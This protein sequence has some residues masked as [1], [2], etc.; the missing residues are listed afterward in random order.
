MT[1]NPYP[2]GIPL[3]EAGRQQRLHAKALE[4]RAIATGNWGQWRHYDVPFGIPGGSGW[5]REI[6]RVA[7]ND[8][9]AVLIRPVQTAWGL[10]HH[11][12][13]RT[14]SN[15]EP[16]WRDKQRIKDELFARDASAIEVMPPSGEV[17]DQADMYHI[18]VLP[19]GFDLPFSLFDARHE[20]NANGVSAQ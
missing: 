17:I 2:L 19:A 14:A 15:F 10:V 8:L 13:I 12:A 5:C 16:P 11:L 9:Y 3:E 18:W 20:S 6:R 1:A 4:R 7:A